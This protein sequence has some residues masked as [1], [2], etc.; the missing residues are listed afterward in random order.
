[1]IIVSTTVLI[2]VLVVFNAMFSQSTDDFVLRA[3]EKRFFPAF[4][5]SEGFVRS[6][7]IN[8]SF[9]GISIAIAS[10]NTNVKDWYFGWFNPGLA[11]ALNLFFGFIVSFCLRNDRAS[12]WAGPKRK[13]VG[14]FIGVAAILF[15]YAVAASANRETSAAS[16][17]PNS[18]GSTEGAS[19]VGLRPRQG[20]VIVE[21]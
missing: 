12:A 19:S 9:A 4:I 21:A 8:L 6:C 11:T 13:V 15:L 14:G 16:D 17:N 2:V 18:K 1:M 5:E 10:R 3:D 7:L 20:L